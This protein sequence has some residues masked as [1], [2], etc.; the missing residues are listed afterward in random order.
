MCADVR[1]EDVPELGY[2]TTDSPYARGEIW[3]RTNLTVPAYAC[4]LCPRIPSLSLFHTTHTHTHAR[5]AHAHTHDR[6]RR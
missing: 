5:R 2:F 1:L 4:L 6:T 3:V